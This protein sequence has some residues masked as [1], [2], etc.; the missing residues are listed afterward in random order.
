[1]TL[2]ERLTALRKKAGLTQQQLGNALETSSQHVSDWEH[3]LVE[4]DLRTLKALSKL[5]GIGINELLEEESAPLEASISSVTAE[6]EEEDESEEEIKVIGYCVRCHR[7]VY[8]G[9]GV[10]TSF[11]LMCRNCAE[12]SSVPQGAS[13]R[14]AVKGH[15]YDVAG[16]NAPRQREPM[17]Y[18][19][20]D[21]A[22]FG[23]AFLSFLMGILGF[24]LFFC[25]RSAG[26]P[27]RAR[28]CLKGALLG[29]LVYFFPIILLT[30]C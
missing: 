12:T 29:L 30:S 17:S 5:Y 2:G 19:E 16:K 22:S 8:S 23:W 9:N 20:N 15:Q 14:G 1:M 3:D 7:A 27:K 10:R 4:P 18:E 21:R 28:S 11:G 24:I 6:S 25:F 13:A 26:Y